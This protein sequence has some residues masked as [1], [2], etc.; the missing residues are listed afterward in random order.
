[1]KV[2]KQ[3]KIIV[4]CFYCQ[5]L[6]NE[7]NYLN[8]IEEV[9]E[10][11]GD[12]PQV[13]VGDFHIDLL[14][15]ELVLRKKLENMMAAHCWSLISLREATRGT[16]ISSSCLDALFGNVPLLKSRIEKTAF[17]DHY[18]LPLKLDLEYEAMECIHRFRCLN[19]LENGDYIENFSFY[20]PHTLGKLKRLVSL[21]KH[22]SRSLMK[23]KKTTAKY[24]P[25]QDLKNFSSL[26]TLITNRFR[27]HMKIRDKLLPLWLKSKSESAHPKCKIKRNEVKM[28]NKLAKWR[29]VQNKI[30]QKIPRSFSV[31][32]GK[33]TEE[34]FLIPKQMEN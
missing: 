1:M 12:I 21:E 30:D 8:H 34:F 2:E 7:N 6:R 22:T 32:L 11:N 15:D 14:L 31:I 17:S 20:S 10:R 16:E 29:D 4:S 26:K 24:F 3:S 28:E 9:L 33:L 23:S 27:T 18:S 5:P 19:K 13:V 25:C